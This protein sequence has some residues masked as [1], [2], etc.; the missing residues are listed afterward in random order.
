MLSHTVTHCLAIWNSYSGQLT[1]QDKDFFDQHAAKALQESGD[2]ILA[3]HQVVQLR[4]QKIGYAPDE[5]IAIA[6]R[7]INEHLQSLADKNLAPVELVQS[8]A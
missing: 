5:S 1:Q 6:Q 3:A 4:L 2:E 8:T 7:L